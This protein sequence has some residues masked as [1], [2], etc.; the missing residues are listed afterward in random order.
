M[1]FLDPFEINSSNYSSF[2]VFVDVDVVNLSGFVI[3][4]ELGQSSRIHC[5]WKSARRGSDEE[6]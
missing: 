1:W 4:A 6:A 5:L 2:G 3:V